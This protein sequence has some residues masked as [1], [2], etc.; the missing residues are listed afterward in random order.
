[1][2]YNIECMGYSGYTIE[3]IKYMGF[4]THPNQ[5]K[6]IFMDSGHF[7]ENIKNMFVDFAHFGTFGSYIVLIS[8]T[9]IL[10]WISTSSQKLSPG[11]HPDSTAAPGYIDKNRGVAKT[12]WHESPTY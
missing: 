8:K 1:M 12:T 6:Y 3:Y 5:F 4:G 11:T 2:G 7:R 10:L 9:E